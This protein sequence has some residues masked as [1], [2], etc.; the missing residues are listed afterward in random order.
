MPTNWTLISQGNVT[1]TLS[2]AEAIQDKNK[3]ESLRQ[4]SAQQPV[5]NG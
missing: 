4:V 5:N 3:Q 1:M 2:E